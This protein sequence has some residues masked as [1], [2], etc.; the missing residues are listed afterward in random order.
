MSIYTDGH[1]PKY[2]ALPRK[3]VPGDA[4]PRDARNTAIILYSM[5]GDAIRRKKI[6]RGAKSPTYSE[7]HEYIPTT[8]PR[9]DYPIE[10]FAISSV[11]YRIWGGRI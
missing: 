10:R 6:A 5:W 8:A 3:P 11:L 4:Y 7:R 1:I 2:E 9:A